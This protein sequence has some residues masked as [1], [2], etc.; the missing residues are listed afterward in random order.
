MTT[1]I[2]CPSWTKSYC[3]LAE[4]TGKLMAWTGPKEQGCFLYLLW[5]RCLSWTKSYCCLVEA[6][7][8]HMRHTSSRIPQDM[9][10]PS[11]G[12]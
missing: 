9:C 8:C 11:T 7:G 4:A 5:I 10:L 12:S 3:C 1:M 2:H 6:T